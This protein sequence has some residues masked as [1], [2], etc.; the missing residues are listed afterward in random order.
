MSHTSDL[1]RSAAATGGALRAFILRLHFY[2]GLFIGPFIFVA[3]LT[4]LLYVVTPQIE[5]RLYADALYTDTTGSARSLTDQALAACAYLETDLDVSA[6]RPATGEGRTTRIMF[7]DGALGPSENRTVFV[8]PVTLEIR[9]D[10][11]TYGT[12]GILPFRITLDYLHR[13]MLMGDWGRYYSELAASWLWVVVLGGVVLW[14]TG[15]KRRRAVRDMP[16]PQ[17]RRWIHATLGMGL[18]VVLVFISITGL[19]WSQAGGQRITDLRNAIGWVTPSASTALDGAVVPMDAHGPSA[20]PNHRMAW[21][22][23][24]HQGRQRS[25]IHQRNSCDLGCEAGHCT[26]PHPA[27][28]AAA[29]RLCR[30][31]QPHRPP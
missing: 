4:G 9:G 27:R 5:D 8:D 25:G 20:E 22:A 18:S 3:A 29:K 11:T 1:P 7:S 15:P 14:A 26:D 31:I 19:T 23:H 13:N 21:Q 30:A 12:S 6:V 10:M 24:G 17:R 16:P 2:I 28:Q